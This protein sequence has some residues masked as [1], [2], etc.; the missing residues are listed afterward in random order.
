MYLSIVFSWFVAML[1]V[2]E[3][4]ILI[5]STLHLLTAMC[6]GRNGRVSSTDHCAV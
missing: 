1:D 6:D 5:R 3:A 4:A 2:I